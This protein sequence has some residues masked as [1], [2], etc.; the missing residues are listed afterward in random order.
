MN[1]S[2]SLPREN[3]PRA[4]C[5]AYYFNSVW[6]NVSALFPTTQDRAGGKCPFKSATP[7]RRVRM[8]GRKEGQAQ[9]KLPVRGQGRPQPSGQHGAARPLPADGAALGQRK[10][11]YPG[12]LVAKRTLRG[13]TGPTVSDPTRNPPLTWPQPGGRGG[14]AH[15]SSGHQR[16]WSSSGALPQ[17][18][19]LQTTGHLQFRHKDTTTQTR[20]CCQPR[21]VHEQATP[22]G[23]NPR[24]PQ[25][26]ARTSQMSAHGACLERAAEAAPPAAAQQPCG[27]RPTTLRQ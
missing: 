19:W 15:T 20:L 10:V 12:A 17:E 26:V 8:E 1:L 7:I 5:S 14:R 9:R 27:H 21:P 13:S 11:L 6:T 16:S 25:T 18:R 23:A 24:C 22:R 3:P 4:P 2:F